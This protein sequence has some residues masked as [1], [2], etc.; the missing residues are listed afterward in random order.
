MVMCGRIIQRVRVHGKV[1][2][3]E[4]YFIGYRKM[5]SKLKKGIAKRLQGTIE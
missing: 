4:F 5:I 3:Q 1:I 2:E